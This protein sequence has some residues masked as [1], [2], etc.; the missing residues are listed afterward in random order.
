[1]AT[2]LAGGA[3]GLA[4]KGGDIAPGRPTRCPYDL[5][6]LTG[7]SFSFDAAVA[8]LEPLVKA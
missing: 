5:A 8:A 6:D 4:A 7:E 3:G 1:M 2:S